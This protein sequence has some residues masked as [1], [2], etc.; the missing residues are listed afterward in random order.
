[1]SVHHYYMVIR[2]TS[3]LFDCNLK[4]DLL[5]SRKET[6]GSVADTDEADVSLAGVLQGADLWSRN[7][8]FWGIIQ[9]FLESGLRFSNLPA[10]RG[11]SFCRSSNRLL[12]SMLVIFLRARRWPV[13]ACAFLIQPAKQTFANELKV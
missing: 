7:R 1:M 10:S 8:R 2:R 11:R 4:L 12:G 6:A 9:H 3:Q 5:K 13:G